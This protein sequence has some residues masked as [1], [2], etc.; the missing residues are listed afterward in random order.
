MHFPTNQNKAVSRWLRSSLYLYFLAKGGRGNRIPDSRL[1][2]G[3]LSVAQRPLLL[4]RTYRCVTTRKPEM[5]GL[6]DC[7]KREVSYISD[8][9]L[10]PSNSANAML[11]FNS[12]AVLLILF[13]IRGV[14]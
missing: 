8:A 7:P 11:H 12:F 9:N 5:H 2:S 4:L 14:S 6:L 13:L 3:P 10:F 1:S